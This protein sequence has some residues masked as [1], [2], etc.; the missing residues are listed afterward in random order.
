MKPEISSLTSLLFILAY[1]PAIVFTQYPP[2]SQAQADLSG[3]SGI[4]GTAIFTAVKGGVKVDISVDGLQSAENDF[5]HIHER[6]VTN[7][8]CE[9]AGGHF[10]PTKKNF[11]CPPRGDQNFCQVGD[12]SATLKGGPLVAKGKGQRA[13]KSY[14]DKIIGLPTIVNLGVVVHAANI[15][16]RLACGNIVCKKP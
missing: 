1:L 16:V 14:V 3:I 8:D 15:K 2:C 5:Y 12:L 10:N 6:A 7:N 9:S 4:K 11:P 13:T